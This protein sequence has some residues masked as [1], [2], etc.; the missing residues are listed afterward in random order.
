[1][2]NMELSP[3]PQHSH[4]AGNEIVARSDTGE[5]APRGVGSD[6]RQPHLEA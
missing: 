4:H 3:S 2:R 1:M 5:T 6:L